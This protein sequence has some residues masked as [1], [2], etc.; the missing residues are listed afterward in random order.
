TV[1]LV[2]LSQEHTLT[3]LRGATGIL[4]HRVLEVREGVVGADSP[5]RGDVRETRQQPVGRRDVQGGFGEVLVT[6]RHLAVLIAVPPFPADP[7]RECDGLTQPPAGIEVGVVLLVAP[8]AG[9][10]GRVDSVVVDGDTP[11]GD[12]AALVGVIVE[13]ILGRERHRVKWPARGVQIHEPRL[14]ETVEA[15]GWQG[16]TRIPGQGRVDRLREE[17][18]VLEVKSP[19]QIRA[20]S[21]AQRQVDAAGQ[22]HRGRHFARR[23]GALPRPPPRRRCR[24]P[25]CQSTDCPPAFAT[26]RFRR[27]TARTRTGAGTADPRR[28][29]AAESRGWYARSAAALRKSWRRGSRKPWP[30]AGRLPC[31][32]GCTR[33]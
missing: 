6:D 3:G 32:S 13:A 20:E 14:H 4:Q 8:A 1:G 30:W 5:E 27:W 12:A 21:R 16:E 26:G 15:V 24:A 33:P 18:V 25:R 23:G 11:E 31:G 28:P 2:E 19:R 29:R 10:P 9:S 7:G 22:A 17:R